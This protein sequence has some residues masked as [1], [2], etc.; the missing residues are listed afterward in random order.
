MPNER[1]RLH[2]AGQKF[3]IYLLTKR[4]SAGGMAE[5][6]LAEEVPELH[7]T[8]STNQANYAPDP[9]RRQV[10]V[11][12]V[13]PTD[14]IT[15]ASGITDIVE[16]FTNEGVL[17]QQLHHP[18][19]LPVY[20]SGAN[21]GYLYHVMEY[22]PNGSLADAICGRAEHILRLPLPLPLAIGIIGQVGT[23]LEYIHARGVVH[24]DVKPG[25]LLVRIDQQ[26]GWHLLLADFGV[27]CCGTNTIRHD[28]QV[29]GTVAYM[30]PE[31][32]SGWFSPAS[33]QY[34][35]AVM[36]FQ[37]LT[38]H[39]PF[40]GT[41]DEQIAGHLQVIAPSARM[42]VED[43]P[44]QIEEVIARALEKRE[45]DR[46]PSVAAFVKELEAASHEAEAGTESAPLAALAAVRAA[47]QAARTAHHP[48]HTSRP[49]YR[50]RA[51][52]TLVAALLLL[53]ATSITLDKFP[54]ISGLGA[55]YTKSI[56]A[57]RPEQSSSGI[58]DLGNAHGGAT[59]PAISKLPKPNT[60]V[61]IATPR[62][63]AVVSIDGAKLVALSLP[64]SVPAG[65]L[66]AFQLTLAN[67]GTSTWIGGEGY[68]LTCDLLRHPAQNCPDG[69][70][71]TLGNYAVT[72]GGEVTF[73]VWLTS[74]STPGI[75][76]AWINM[77]Q[78]N[79]PFQTQDI[80]VRVQTL[81]ESIPPASTSPPAGQGAK[82]SIQT[83]PTPLARQHHPQRLQPFHLRLLSLPLLQAPAA[84]ASL[85][86]RLEPVTN[87]RQI[88]HGS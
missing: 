88:W 85:P 70:E 68:R 45:V 1:L 78:G 58:S 67:T 75:Y 19:I 56:S 35:L 64:S 76:T 28:D 13:C 30:A 34:S 27:A 73:Q 16:R 4:I 9:L 23:A 5:V 33:D 14:E 65:Q 26:N 52:L 51:V 81:A 72:P 3:G 84:S 57:A 39:L 18:H 42:Y 6:Y 61:P 46:Y 15:L 40:E 7:E 74:L 47:T 66:F 21:R 69:F 25:N 11:K 38:G 17:L 12:V 77:A 79:A 29:T 59:T 31:V 87:R 8:G 48:A 62:E 41:I 49:P 44:W 80:V 54:G 36:A 63:P 71:A 55:N 24:R 83:P 60:P 82:R 50:V 53:L 32:F 37:L 2:L 20:A 10:A 86:H 22:V 43:V